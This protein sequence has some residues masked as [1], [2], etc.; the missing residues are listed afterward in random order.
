MI[1]LLGTNHHLRLLLNSALGPTQSKVLLL[2]QPC[3]NDPFAPTAPPHLPKP[4]Q[5]T[6]PL[7]DQ[8]PLVQLRN[9]KARMN[10]TIGHISHVSWEEAI[11]S[12]AIS[13]FRL[14]GP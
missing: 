5:V 6:P 12:S 2:L 1:K 14:L 11:K 9:E 10:F 3:V 4:G 8:D 13:R 7:R